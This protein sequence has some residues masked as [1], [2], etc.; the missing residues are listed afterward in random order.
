MAIVS[1]ATPSVLK[2]ASLMRVDSVRLAINIV[3]AGL[4]AM[5]AYRGQARSHKT[6]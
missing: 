3:G 4:P 1:S 6:H 5:N 2:C